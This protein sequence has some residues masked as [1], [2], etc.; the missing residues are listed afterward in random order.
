MVA[1]QTFF[2]TSRHLLFFVVNKF[3]YFS[4]CC[5]TDSKEKKEKRVKKKE[6]KKSPM[7]NKHPYL[8]EPST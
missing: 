1:F 5:K 6:K 8:S 3:L 2:V 4:H 7:K